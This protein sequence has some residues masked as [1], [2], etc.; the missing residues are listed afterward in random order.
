[1]PMCLHTSLWL[2]L[3]TNPTENMFRNKVRKIYFIYKCIRMHLNRAFIHMS[4]VPDYEHHQQVLFYFETLT[5]VVKLGLAWNDQSHGEPASHILDDKL[6]HFFDILAAL[7][8]GHSIAEVLV[9]FASTIRL[10]LIISNSLTHWPPRLTTLLIVIVV[11]V[12]WLKS[13]WRWF[14]QLILCFFIGGPPLPCRNI[15]AFHS[16]FPIF[17]WSRRRWAD[18]RRT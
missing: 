5:I 7:F 13:T 17:S 12:L 15:L 18:I 1:M 2:Y 8:E 3:D 10:C 11:I 6:C 4:L 9:N 16:S 14:R